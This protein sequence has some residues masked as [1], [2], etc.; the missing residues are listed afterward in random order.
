[1]AEI[2]EIGLICHR[3]RNLKKKR[4]QIATLV[5]EQYIPPKEMWDFF[6]NYR[7]KGAFLFC[8]DCLKEVRKQYKMDEEGPQLY[9]GED[10]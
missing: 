7:H 8:M 6:H 9:R 4:V 1:M 10:V 3:C 5:S 2:F